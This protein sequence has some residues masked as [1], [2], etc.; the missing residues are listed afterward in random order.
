MR[1]DPLDPAAPAAAQDTAARPWPQLPSVDKLLQSAD[2]APL[3]TQ[4]GHQACTQ[5]L[6]ETLDGLRDQLHAGMVLAPEATD[7]ARIAHAA[8]Q[9]LAR[10][11]AP[12][13]QAV[14]NL[15][16]TVLHTNLGRALLPQEAV[17]AV[18]QAL[19]SPANL[20]YDLA[21]GGRG[22]RDDLIEALVCELTGAEAATVVNNNA[23]AVLLTLGTLAEG[24][25]V[26][27]SRGEL[28]EI[29]GAFRIPDIMARAGARLVEVGTTNRTHARDY[30]EAVSADTGLLMKVHC[31]NYEVTGFT[32]SVSDHE[33]ADIAHGRGLSMVVDLG[34]GTLVDMRQWGLPYEVTVRET[35]AAGADIVTFSG[36]KLLGGPQAGLIVGRKDLIARI[37]KNPLKR[38]MRVGKLTL[39]ALE[40][41]LRLYLHPEQ[42]ARRLTT[43]R[44]F[45]RP[46]ADMQA[47]AETLAPALQA[48]LGPAYVVETAAMASQIGSGALPVESLPSHG[49]RIHPASGRQAGRQ[50]MQLEAA[51]RALPRPVIGRIQA[52]ALWLD[53]RCLE[54]DQQALFAGQL[55]LLAAHAA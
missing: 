10:R 32:K 25:E 6:R 23:A 4:Y 54:A 13:L 45:T 21:T 53:L 36:D 40:P 51:L 41:V 3:R 55:P 22:D 46:A 12:R 31:S 18:V 42:L 20:E 8:R 27:V 30:T 44:L 24:R 17:D 49:L 1:T 33:V 37:K 9:R 5:A 19:L 35:I 26:I 43:L 29:G 16:G 14:F 52:D 38:A 15:T 47:Q 39:A 28:V 48:A 50:L 7:F 11:F 34:S 2:V